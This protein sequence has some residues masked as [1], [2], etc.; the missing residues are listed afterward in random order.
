[1]SYNEWVSEN[2]DELKAKYNEFY[3][4]E[5]AKGVEKVQTFPAW[6]SDYAEYLEQEAIDQQVDGYREAEWLRRHE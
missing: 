5:K 4:E 6:C 3:R 2:Y 1:M